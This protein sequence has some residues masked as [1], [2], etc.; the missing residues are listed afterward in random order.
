MWDQVSDLL[1]KRQAAVGHESTLIPV[2][3]E[4]GLRLMR[5]H[6][7]MGGQEPAL[8][9]A[10]VALN[11]SSDFTEQRSAEF[12]VTCHD[13]LMTSTK[14]EDHEDA[15]DLLLKAAKLLETQDDAALMIQAGSALLVHSD[16]HEPTALPIVRRGLK[17][18]NLGAEDPDWTVIHGAVSQLSRAKLAKECHELVLKIIDEQG[19]AKVPAIHRGALFNSWSD[20]AVSVAPRSEVVSILRLAAKSFSGST[21]LPVSMRTAV[22]LKIISLYLGGKPEDLLTKIDKEEGLKACEEAFSVVSLLDPRARN[23]AIDALYASVLTAFGTALRLNGHRA[24]AKGAF[25]RAL[26]CMMSD[27]AD[28]TGT[29]KEEIIANLTSMPDVE[30][31]SLDEYKPGRAGGKS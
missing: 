8:D 31:R 13:V 18:L 25:V 6:T 7:A 1:L 10:L 5:L 16:E 4:V 2:V 14:T 29:K 20:V 23:P 30:A 3:C 12:L 17:S 24:F 9:C 28:P 22:M 15:L 19:M 26:G 11:R 21:F 27:Q